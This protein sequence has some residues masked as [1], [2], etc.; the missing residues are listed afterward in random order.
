MGRIELGTRRVCIPLTAILLLALL[1]GAAALYVDGHGARGLP[2]LEVIE[3]PVVALSALGARLRV[4]WLLVFVAAAGATGV[5]WCN[6]REGFAGRSPRL[7]AGLA[8]AWA[9]Q[10]L[11]LGPLPVLGLA[12]YAV[13]LLFVSLRRGPP[14]AVQ[15][16]APRPREL[17]VLAGLLACVLVLCIHQLDVFPEVNLDEVAYW[18]AARMQLGRLSSEGSIFHVYVLD[19]FQA[20]LIPYYLYAAAVAALDPGVLSLRFISVAAAASTLLVVALGLRSRIGAAAVFWTLAFCIASPL[21]LAFSRMGLYLALSPLHGALSFVATLAFLERRDRRS[22]L[23][24]GVLIGSALFLYQLSWF[25]GLLV[26][27]GLATQP[28]LW[29]CPA[30]RRR[31]ALV[32]VAAVA[33]AL[34]GWVVLREEFSALGAQTFDK[35]IVPGLAGESGFVLLKPPEELET[36]VAEETAKRLAQGGVKTSWGGHGIL[37]VGGSKD[38]VAEALRSPAIEGWLRLSRLLPRSGNPWSEMKQVLDQLFWRP[39][40]APSAGGVIVAAP[41]LNPILAPLLVLGWIE[42]WRRRRDPTM[43]LLLIWVTGGLLLPAAVA[44]AAPRRCILVLPFAQVLMALSLLAVGEALRLRRRV[45]VALGAAL[46]VV[47]TA[48]GVHLYFEHWN[49]RLAEFPRHGLL[50]LVRVLKADRSEGPVL[51]PTGLLYHRNPELANVLLGGIDRDGPNPGR[52]V[53]VT[54]RQIEGRGRLRRF[55]CRQPTP[56]SWVV[57]EDP[58]LLDRFEPL[59]RDFVLEQRH[60]GNH[61]WLVA[62]AKKPTGCR[63]PFRRQQLGVSPP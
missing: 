43:R 29:R 35:A 51:I 54:R 37:A 9:A 3:G 44:G 52:W 39:H 62:K 48:T 33:V 59:E 30:G 31:T 2:L 15:P 46:L 49:D 24:L 1:L 8:I 16:A 10:V 60:E 27:A 23:V 26:A 14:A 55:S 61:R 58:E 12:A 63:G 19:R 7:L 18:K 36:W 20:Q 32:A 4:P 11:L 53:Q 47:A 57:P 25:V 45:A 34:P 56:F 28:E 5:A 22:A 38:A 21:F 17:V 42:A 6:R 13:A 50:E 41:D 40:I